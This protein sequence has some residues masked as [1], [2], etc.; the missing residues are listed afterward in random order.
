MVL[1][2]LPC[3]ERRIWYFR[4]ICRVRCLSAAVELESPD[5]L[6]APL[7]VPCETDAGNAPILLDPEVLIHEESIDKYVHFTYTEFIHCAFSTTRRENRKGGWASVRARPQ[8][9]LI[10]GDCRCTRVCAQRQLHALVRSMVT[11]VLV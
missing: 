7:A 8:R 3:P 5:R 9:R 10:K 1:R 6:H 4:S 2:T 11:E